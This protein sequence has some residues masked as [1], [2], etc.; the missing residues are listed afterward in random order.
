M[1]LVVRP[2]SHDRVRNLPFANSTQT[3]P[4]PNVLAVPSYTLEPRRAIC[5]ALI[6]RFQ[7][8]HPLRPGVFSKAMVENMAE[9]GP[10]IVVFWVRL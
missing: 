6:P 5:S 1:P 2:T 7:P 4:S 10:I 8:T 9:A 3:Q